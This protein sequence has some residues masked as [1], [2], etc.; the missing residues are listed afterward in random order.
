MIV[1]QMLKSGRRQLL[2]GGTH[3][4]RCTRPRARPQADPLRR[5]W[6]RSDDRRR[7]AEVNLVTPHGADLRWGWCRHSRAWHP[8]RLIARS[9][10]PTPAR[11]RQSRPV[12]IYCPGATVDAEA[13][14]NSADQA[15]EMVLLRINVIVFG[16]TARCVRILTPFWLAMVW[17]L[18]SAAHVSLRS[19]GPGMRRLV[20][21]LAG[22]VAGTV[23]S[24]SRSATPSA[25]PASRLTLYADPRRRRRPD[26]GLRAT[27]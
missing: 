10:A 19:R 25:A 13:L 20:I 17:H 11:R 7:M 12:L 21:L 24:A 6:G 26:A 3:A 9:S 2:G 27:A 15:S 1:V 23:S 8:A 22:L 14:S 5:R 16:R 18:S 4:G